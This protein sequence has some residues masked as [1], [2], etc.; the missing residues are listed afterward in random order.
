[1]DNYNH[2]NASIL[3]LI[4][5][6]IN[7]RNISRNINKKIFR[8]DKILN[9]NTQNCKYVGGKNKMEIK[10]HLQIK[11]TSPDENGTICMSILLDKYQDLIYE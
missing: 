3:T 2:L 9:I 8:V 4:L 7:N 10:K 1:M 6:K 5:E 11:F